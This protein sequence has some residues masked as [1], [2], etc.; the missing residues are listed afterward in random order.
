M[1]HRSGETGFKTT[2]FT[3]RKPHVVVTE[4]F[5]D[6]RL[7]RQLV[8][9]LPDDYAFPD[10]LDVC[11]ATRDELLVESDAEQFSIEV[12]M[13]T[14]KG[15]ACEHEGGDYV[16]GG[17][18]G[19]NYNAKL[20]DREKNLGTW[21]L[22]FFKQAD[23]KL[24]ATGSQRRA[25]TF[26][27]FHDVLEIMRRGLAAWF[28][29]KR[30]KLFNVPKK[31]PV[32]AVGFNDMLIKTLALSQFESIGRYRSFCDTTT[33]LD[34]N[35]KFEIQWAAICEY[36]QLPHK[37][38][39]YVC[40]NKIAEM[41][42]EQQAILSQLK[43]E[44]KKKKEKEKKQWLEARRRL[45]YGRDS[46]DNDRPDNDRETQLARTRSAL[47]QPRIIQ[48]GAGEA[49]ARPAERAS[50]RP[51]ERASARPAERADRAMPP[52]PSFGPSRTSA[53]VPLFG[54]G[55]A[56]NGSGLPPWMRKQ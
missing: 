27:E 42:R 46:P 34:E 8:K 22:D 47:V 17:G 15:A 12:S 21:L 48:F 43:Q 3:C 16:C 32:L 54:A 40:K 20:Q 50:A 53:A 2:S 26:Q 6:G 29:V 5:S 7:G 35:M 52:V 10:C 19:R 24:A 55:R 39:A 30:L 45:I 38:V 11:V 31:T 33:K 25:V 49:S 14:A 23:A 9:Q 41:R 44:K 37:P 1:P 18:F 13:R 28:T 51:A 4:R 36:A 56:V